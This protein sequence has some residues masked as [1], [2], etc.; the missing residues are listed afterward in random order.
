VRSQDE[1]ASVEQKAATIAGNGNVTN[2][3]EIAPPKS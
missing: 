1:K 3:L 2:E